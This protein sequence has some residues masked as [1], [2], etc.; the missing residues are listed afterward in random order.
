MSMGGGCE[1]GSR[2]RGCRWVPDGSIGRAAAAARFKKSNALQKISS[3][4]NNEYG[5]YFMAAKYEEVNWEVM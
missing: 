2:G 5:M 1:P 3:E 4:E